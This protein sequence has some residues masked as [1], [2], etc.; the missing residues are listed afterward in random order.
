[1]ARF[2]RHAVQLGRRTKRHELDEQTERRL[3]LERLIELTGE[4]ARRLSAGL[5]DRE[6]NIPW[7]DIIGMRL[8]LVH[9]YDKIEPDILWG[10]IRNMPSLL[11]QLDT[12]LK[13]GR[14]RR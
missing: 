9:D 1:M 4:A 6:S 13:L 10:T 3:A 11:R 12:I 7:E 8:K 2:A 14:Q 5:R